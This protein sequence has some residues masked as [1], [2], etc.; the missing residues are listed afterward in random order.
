MDSLDLLTDRLF[1]YAGMFPPA[2]LSFEDALAESAGFPATLHRPGLVAAD[3]VLTP[4]ALERLDE[5]ALA[6]AGFDRECTVCLVGVPA[7]QALPTAA[8]IKA[9]NRDRNGNS[10]DDDGAP[11]QRIVSLELHFDEMPDPAAI[12]AARRQL[13]AAVQ[14]YVEPK[15]PD[16]ALAER[17]PDAMAFLDALNDDRGDAPAVGFKV[18]CAGP[19]ALSHGTLG[20]VLEAVA[21]RRV[22]V[23][24]TQGLHHPFAFDTDHQNEHG[25]LNV[26]AALRFAQAG[27]LG[28]DDLVDLLRDPDP[29][30]FAFEDGLGWN[31]HRLLTQRLREALEVP[32]AIGSCS[33]AEPDEDLQALYG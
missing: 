5:D 27:A 30:S 28:G 14:V 22:P 26:A 2:A 33:L 29:A 25:F 21:E 23:K 31:G 15:W 16:T 9:F 18:R 3:M 17:M 24:T 6:T 1:D 12:D 4:D 32:F 7:E 13:G 8:A 19:T 11:R 10:G 20:R